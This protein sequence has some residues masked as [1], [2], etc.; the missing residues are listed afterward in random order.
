MIEKEIKVRIED[1]R[2]HDLVH[3]MIT[4]DQGRLEV[5][6]MVE[7]IERTALMMLDMKGVR[8]GGTAKRSVIVNIILW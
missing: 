7:V 5:E 3:V 2:D 6:A 8:S 4:L 1:M